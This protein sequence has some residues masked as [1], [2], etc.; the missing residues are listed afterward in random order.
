[1]S[2]YTLKS[3]I[4]MSV[5]IKQQSLDIDETGRTKQVVN[6]DKNQKEG[7]SKYRWS[8]H[9][10]RDVSL[11]CSH[12]P[13]SKCKIKK[14]LIVTKRTG[15]L[16]QKNMIVVALLQEGQVLSLKMQLIAN[17]CNPDMRLIKSLW[18]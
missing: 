10:I 12:V 6:T 2:N 13:F 17:C 15:A 3:K 5:K 8:K 18:E 9:R 7:M 16:L 4:Q 14:W 11:L 1:M